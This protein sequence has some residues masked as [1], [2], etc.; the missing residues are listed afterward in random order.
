MPDLFRKLIADELWCLIPY[1][2]ELEGEIIELAPGMAL[3]FVQLAD[4]HGAVV[5]IF[6][7]Q[8]RVDEG[9]ETGNV[10]PMTFVPAAMPAVQ[11]LSLIGG[12]GLR[13]VLNKGCNTGQITLPPELLRDLADG[14]ALRPHHL[15][16]ERGLHQGMLKH[17]DPADYPTELVQRLFE[18][19]RR[20]SHFRAAWIF[21]LPEEEGV[22]QDPPRYQVLVWM[23]PRDDG[24][25]HDLSLVARTRSDSSEHVELGLLDEMNPEYIESLRQQVHPFYVAAK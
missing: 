20:H 14:T 6:S 18:A 5:P 15:E 11:L 2:P 23:D 19:L 25:F 8:E 7:C 12:A 16:A 17:V 21:I 3:P 9:L 24:V 4:S 1:H 22:R 10:E 13:A